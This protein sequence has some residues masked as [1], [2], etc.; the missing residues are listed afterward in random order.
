ME[1][2]TGAAWSARANN[3]CYRIREL[4][5]P[6][7]T[8]T[9]LQRFEFKTT[10]LSHNAGQLLIRSYGQERYTEIAVGQEIAFESGAEGEIVNAADREFQFTVTEFK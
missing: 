4:T 3:P 2:A 5:L 1:A 6:G 10:F 7:A 8:S 9:G